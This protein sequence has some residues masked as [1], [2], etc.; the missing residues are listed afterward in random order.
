VK[1]YILKKRLRETRKGAGWEEGYRTRG[2]NGLIGK[3]NQAIIR[4][5]LTQRKR[6]RREKQ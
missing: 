3:G 6:K 2:R 4:F 1:A 5:D